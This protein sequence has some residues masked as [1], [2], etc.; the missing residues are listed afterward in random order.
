MQVEKLHQEKALLKKEASSLKREKESLQVGDRQMQCLNW[1]A[2]CP[3]TD[4]QGSGLI[5]NPCPGWPKIR[6]IVSKGILLHFTVS[7]ARQ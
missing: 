6:G 3:E 1:R 5:R 2:W 4:R 7:R